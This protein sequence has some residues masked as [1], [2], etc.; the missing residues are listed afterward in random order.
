ME[1][2]NTIVVTKDL[3]VGDRV[4]QQNGYGLEVAQIVERGV[5]VDLIYRDSVDGKWRN[6]GHR[7]LYEWNEKIPT[8][9]NL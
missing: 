7:C 4:P 1:K 3:K 6:L 2:C 9:Q 5:L 8:M